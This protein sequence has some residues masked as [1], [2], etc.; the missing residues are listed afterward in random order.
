MWEQ[1]SL[2]WQASLREAWSAYCAGCIPIGAAVAT[3][4]GAVL[5]TGRNRINT[6]RE[7]AYDYLS[8]VRLAHAEINA[9]LALQGRV[10]NARECVLYTTTEPCPMCAGAIV[11]CNLRAVRFAARDPWAGATEL[12]QTNRYMY[13]KHM[14]VEGPLALEPVLFSMQTEFFL[15]EGV[16]RNGGL[17]PLTGLEP[18]LES[19]AVIHPEAVAL[20]RSLYESGQLRQMRDEGESIQQVLQ[21][22]QAMLV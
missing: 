16:R 13:S 14:Q 15:A 11:M 10:G 5:A 18:L 4:D 19:M 22:L 20:G 9:L 21:N 12:Y 6:P 1:L 8:G 2:P 3:A 17:H 7:T